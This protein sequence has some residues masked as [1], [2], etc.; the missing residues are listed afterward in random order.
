MTPIRRCE[1][2]NI[3][4]LLGIFASL[5]ITW[6]LNVKEEKSIKSMIM[7][8]S[9]YSKVINLQSENVNEIKINPKYA[10]ISINFC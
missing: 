1:I 9:F 2:L 8:M 7:K 10:Y 3:K 5:A 4:I 6:Y